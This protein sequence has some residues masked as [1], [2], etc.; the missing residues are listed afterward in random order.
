[1]WTNNY[2]RS[3]LDALQSICVKHFNTCGFRWIHAHQTSLKLHHLHVASFLV[4]VYPA[5][6]QLLPPPS[7]ELWPHMQWLQGWQPGSYRGLLTSLTCQQTG[8]TFSNRRNELAPRNS[9]T[10]LDEANPRDGWPLCWSTYLRTPSDHGRCR[11]RHRVTRWRL[12]CF[13]SSLCSSSYLSLSSWKVM[14]S[15]STNLNSV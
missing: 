13:F 4:F 5:N 15:W 2:S 9:A 1:M 8:G 12:C 3:C 14:L 10:E 7:S 11:P 6:M